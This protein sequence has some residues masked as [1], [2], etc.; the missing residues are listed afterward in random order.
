MR[1]RNVTQFAVPFAALLRGMRTAGGKV[2]A[3]RQVGGIRRQPLDGRQP[4]HVLGQIG[5]RAKQPLGVRVAGIGVSRPSSSQPK[6]CSQE[7]VAK[8][9]FMLMS[10]KLYGQIKGEIKERI[11]RV[12]TTISPA[13]A[14]GRLRIRFHTYGSEPGTSDFTI[15]AAAAPFVL[16]LLLALIFY[17]ARTFVSFLKPPSFLVV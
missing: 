15:F 1:S 16:F 8:L 7:G 5:D 6:G 12:T 3:L 13:I 4:G 14:S 17:Q 2:A 9:S 11:S 10:L